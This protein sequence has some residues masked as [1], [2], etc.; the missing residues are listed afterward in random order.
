MADCMRPTQIQTMI[1][2]PAWID[3]IPWPEIR[4]YLINQPAHAIIDEDTPALFARSM[5]ITGRKARNDG[6]M[7]PMVSPWSNSPVQDDELKNWVDD[8]NNWALDRAAVDRFPAIANMAWI[9]DEERGDMSRVR[10][11]GFRGMMEF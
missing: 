3:Y 6:S 1:P 5:R 9:L 8:L 7:L 10:L 11:A 2:H 4:D